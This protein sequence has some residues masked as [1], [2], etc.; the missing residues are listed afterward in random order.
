[1]RTPVARLVVG[2]KPIVDLNA[3]CLLE[4]E[5][6]IH[7]LWRTPGGESLHAR[8]AYML[9]RASTLQIRGRPA[10][11][12]GARFAA[13]EQY[14]VR[15]GLDIFVVP[16]FAQTTLGIDPSAIQRSLETNYPIRFQGDAIVRGVVQWVDGA[17][18]ALHYRGHELKRG[19]IWLQR[20]PT[21]AGYL[22]YGYTGWQWNVLPA[23]VD[24][25]DC[26]EMLPVADAY[27]TWAGALGFASANHY[28]ITK[29]EDGQHNIG[30]HSDKAKDIA[31][32]SLITIVKTSEHARPFEVCFPGEESK[33]FFRR[34][35][36]P[37]TAAI[38]TLAANLATKHGVPVVDECG[39]SG[40]IVFRTIATTISPEQAA[41]ELAR[42]ACGEVRAQ[43]HALVDSTTPGEGPLDIV[44]LLREYLR[45]AASGAADISSDEEEVPAR[46]SARKSRAGPTHHKRLRTASSVHAHCADTAPD[47][48]AARAAR[49]AE[50]AA[51]SDEAGVL[52]TVEA[53]EIALDPEE[54]GREAAMGVYSGAEEA[55]VETESEEEA[56]PKTTA[57]LLQAIEHN[58]GLMLGPDVPSNVAKWA[59]DAF[60][61]AGGE[62]LVHTRGQ[63]LPDQYCVVKVRHGRVG[64]T[65]PTFG[66]RVGPTAPT[67]ATTLSL[68][69][70]QAPS[71]FSGS[72][73]TRFHLVSTL[74]RMRMV[75]VGKP[76]S[77]VPFEGG[78]DMKGQQMM[79]LR[80]D[81]VIAR[82]QLAS[83]LNA[84]ILAAV[85]KPLRVDTPQWV[86]MRAL[87]RAGLS[88]CPMSG[89]PVFD[90]DQASPK[91][92]KAIW[93]A[94]CGVA[95][96]INSKQVSTTEASLVELARQLALH[97][98]APAE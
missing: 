58:F 91:L 40:S 59:C 5:Q 69:F 39:S 34:V 3:H 14:R 76:L 28:I 41:S 2:G 32:D 79:L 8:H 67:V 64:P 27:D 97:A 29:Y 22:R 37:G 92:Q 66:S 7:A 83:T 31:P 35:L 85:Y 10:L 23:T 48:R 19:K 56:L 1:M 13:L 25:V 74:L 46:Q 44:S 6:T 65:A 11:H 51:A 62:G 52:E 60:Q 21:T 77:S 18:P 61:A 4:R 78:K 55:V 38:M 94:Y 24:V 95:E 54:V 16:N 71:G 50:A 81:A 33:P 36:A 98:A 88:T 63:G 72:L 96:T 30:F 80:E 82:R 12:A 9:P 89:M 70:A 47:T 17:H 73:P 42:R 53:D 68:T 93:K 86:L 15:S 45:R 20:G 90:P 87:H 75:S 57:E 84:E 26:R 43:V 49:R